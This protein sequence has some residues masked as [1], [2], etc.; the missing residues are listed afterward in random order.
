MKV[1]LN[2]KSAIKWLS[3][4][5]FVN[6]IYTGFLNPIMPFIAAKLGF[7]MSLA[8]VLIAITQICSNMFQPVFGF[9]ADNL[10]KRFFVFW[11][12]ILVSIFIPLASVAPNIYLLTLFMI[13]GC[14]GS[15]FFHP[16]S[17][18]FVNIF[19]GQN[20]SVDM[21]IFI[22]MGSLGFAFG[23]LIVALI[24][25]N[26]GLEN[27]VYTSLLGLLI[28][29]LMFK[30]VPKLSNSIEQPIKKEFFSSFKEILSNRQIDYLLFISMMKSL[31]TNSS[32]ILLPFLWKSLG[33]S[34]FYIG[35]AL[36]LFVFMGALGSFVS[37]KAE[38]KYGSKP[39]MYFSMWIT[40]PLMCLF[41]LTYKTM[42]ILSL[43][44]FALMGFTTM[45]AQPITMVW[46]QK[47]HYSRHGILRAG[48]RNFSP[49]S[50]GGKRIARHRQSRCCA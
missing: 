22:S 33:Y 18:G 32:C 42:P 50:L 21:G 27:I 43:A 46:A 36:F 47:T 28:A 4:A 11:G 19:S 2:S 34:A 20:C 41:A 30:F 13:L 40:F 5:H 31:V 45:L 17:S 48:K 23:P 49:E 39:T 24:I 14:L 26:F 25:Q 10:L 12:L 1:V 8:T 9:F 16:Q 38:K 15:S 7:T 35:I 29:L 37:P 6:D 44:I 3:S